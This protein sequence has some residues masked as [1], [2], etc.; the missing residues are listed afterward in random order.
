MNEYSDEER[1]LL[2]RLAHRAIA[3]ELRQEELD[4]SSSV[5]APRRAA[6]RIYH[7]APVWSL[8]RLHRLRRATLSALPNHCRYRGRG[9]VSRSS[10][11]AGHG[12]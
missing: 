7:P 2:L 11:C 4:T 12:R 5:R 1:K 9:G 6:R 3:A 8:A 10:L